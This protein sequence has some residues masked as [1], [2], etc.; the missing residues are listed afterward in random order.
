MQTGQDTCGIPRNPGP[1]S[2]N[3]HAR[4]DGTHF[5]G[6]RNRKQDGRSC[7]YCNSKFH[8]LRNCD[9]AVNVLKNVSRKVAA[10]K[11]N[12]RKFFSKLETKSMNFWLKNMFSSKTTVPIHHHHPRTTRIRLMKTKRMRR[13]PIVRKMI[14][15]TIQ[16]LKMIPPPTRKIFRG[17]LKAPTKSTLQIRSQQN[18][19]QNESEK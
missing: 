17:E 8:H 12:A 9:K 4:N 5:D 14:Q 19:V 18:K 15:E 2:S 11:N 13:R 16:D 1:S 10:N 7:W 6:Y 3:P